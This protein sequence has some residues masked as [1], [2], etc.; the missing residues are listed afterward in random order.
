MNRPS[1][2]ISLRV[3]QELWEKVNFLVEKGK[4]RN[5]SDALRSLIEGGLWLDSHKKELQD[6]K[7]IQ[8]LIEEWNSKMNEKEIFDW[9]KQLPDGTKEAVGMALELEKTR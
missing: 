4:C 7:R 2:T 6:P 9:V 5:F 8:Q 3:S 1:A